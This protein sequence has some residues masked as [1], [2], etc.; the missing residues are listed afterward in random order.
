MR[1]A[2]RCRRVEVI[3]NADDAD[4]ESEAGGEAS[5]GQ[6]LEPVDAAD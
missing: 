6:L 1:R 2:P 5:A 4:A 3:A